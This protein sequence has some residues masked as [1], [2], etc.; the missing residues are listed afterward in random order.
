MY[1]VFI[2]YLL[3]L[4]K[5]QILFYFALSSILS[6]MDPVGMVPGRFSFL[7][8]ASSLGPNTF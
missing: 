6:W 7:S 2:L 1:I 8:L 3:Y 4:I 5:G